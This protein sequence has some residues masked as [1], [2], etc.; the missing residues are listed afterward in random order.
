MAHSSTDLS[1]RNGLHGS[2]HRVKW[3]MQDHASRPRFRAT[4]V[5]IKDRATIVWRTFVPL[6]TPTRPKHGAHP[7]ALDSWSPDVNPC[8]WSNV[9]LARHSPTGVPSRSGARSRYFNRPIHLRPVNAAVIVERAR[10]RHRGGPGAPTRVED[11]PICGRSRRIPD[12]GMNIATNILE[13]DRVSFVRSGIRWTEGKARCAAAGHCVNFDSLRCGAIATVR[14]RH[15]HRHRG[16]GLT[17][18]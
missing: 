3:A 16:T 10:V 7:A 15:V 13:Q 1:N 8:G 6:S 17:R 18:W 9:P 11:W 14:R 2:V 12:D 5:V 4:V